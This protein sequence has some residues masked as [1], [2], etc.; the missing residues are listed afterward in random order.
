MKVPKDFFPGQAARYNSLSVEDAI[1][2]NNVNAFFAYDP[3]Q[4]V[5]T[6]P[7]RHGP[8]KVYRRIVALADPVKLGYFIKWYLEILKQ[9]RYTATSSGYNDYGLDPLAFEL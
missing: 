5:N 6:G 7:I 2:V 9:R 3:H 4:P 1:L 8:T